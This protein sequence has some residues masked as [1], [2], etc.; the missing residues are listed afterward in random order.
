MRS[1]AGFGQLEFDILPKTTLVGC[2]RYGHEKIQYG[3]NDI[4]NKAFFSGGDGDDFVT[5]KAGL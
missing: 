2:L 3:F 5:Y 4:L 1:Y